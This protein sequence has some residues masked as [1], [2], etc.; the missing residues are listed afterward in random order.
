[1]GSLDYKHYV[2][3]LT[4][5]ILIAFASWSDEDIFNCIQWLILIKIEVQST[6]DNNR[7]IV[8]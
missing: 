7:N 2:F 4:T 6:Y 5:N 1:M 3:L 8:E